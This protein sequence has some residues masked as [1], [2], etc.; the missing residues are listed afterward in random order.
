MAQSGHSSLPPLQC[1]LKYVAG[2]TF[3]LYLFHM[4]L[5][6]L[7]GVHATSI[8]FQ[9]SPLASVLLYF[10]VFAV[11]FALAAVTERKKHWWKK[12][13]GTLSRQPA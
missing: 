11:I 7:I 10:G 5:L 3:S 9:P 12:L 13:F 2:A 4:P 6:G 8:G 1:S